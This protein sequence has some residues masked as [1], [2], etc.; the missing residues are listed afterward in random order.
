M[1]VTLS[2]EA[3]NIEQNNKVASHVGTDNS[4]QCLRQIP[5]ELSWIV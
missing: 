2:C 1:A 4:P 3:G 5:A